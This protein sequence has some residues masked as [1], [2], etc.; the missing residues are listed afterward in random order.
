[1]VPQCGQIFANEIGIKVHF[2]GYHGVLLQKDWTAL[3]CKLIQ[4]FELVREGEIDAD[5]DVLERREGG[6]EVEVE[7]RMGTGEGGLEEWRK[8]P[9]GKYPKKRGIGRGCKRDRKGRISEWK[10][11]ELSRETRK[12]RQQWTEKGGVRNS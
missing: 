12:I 3:R 9:R 8:T 11:D 1:M 4:R 7:V 5:A 6:V 10:W 2:T